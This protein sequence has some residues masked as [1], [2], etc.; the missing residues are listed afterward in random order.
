MSCSKCC[1]IPVKKGLLQHDKAIDGFRQ[2]FSDNLKWVDGSG[3][4]NNRTLDQ[5]MAV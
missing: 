1:A 5:V 2:Y 3:Q 4:D